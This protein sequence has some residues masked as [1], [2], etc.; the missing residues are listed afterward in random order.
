MSGISSDRVGF[1]SPER[2]SVPRHHSVSLELIASTALV[3]CTI[4]AAA[5]VSIG[6]ARAEAIAASPAND[7][8]YAAVLV[9]VILAGFG[10]LTAVMAH[11]EARKPRLD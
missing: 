5:V 3:L 4:V 2:Q 1:C 6:M 9:G 8:L 11:V 7:S 10:G